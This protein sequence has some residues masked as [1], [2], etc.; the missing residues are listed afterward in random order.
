MLKCALRISWQGGLGQPIHSPSD[1][2]LGCQGN[3]A[4]VYS[5]A[6]YM[7]EETGALIW[8]VRR[9]CVKACRVIHPDWDFCVRKVLSFNQLHIKG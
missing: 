9:I 4:D 3:H 2:Q 7:R 1:K 6:Y 5:F 8:D